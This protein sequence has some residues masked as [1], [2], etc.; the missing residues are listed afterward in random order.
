MNQNRLFIKFSSAFLGFI[1]LPFMLILIFLLLRA[2]RLQVQ[3]N[4]SQNEILENQT[5]SAVLQQMK[6]AENMCKTVI[7]NQNLLDFLDKQYETTPD[8]LYYRTTIRD[9]VKVTNGVSDIKLRIYLE[10]TT[11]PMGFGIFLPH[12]LY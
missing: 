6:L 2:N 5:V 8:L 11:I 1:L 10:N 3:Y 4:L 12:L 7:Q 9:F